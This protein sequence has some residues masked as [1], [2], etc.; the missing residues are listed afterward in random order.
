MERRKRRI[1]LTKPHGTHALE[2]H[3]SNVDSH[4]RSL[5]TM[6]AKAFPATYRQV[7]D[8]RLDRCHRSLMPCNVS[9]L[10]I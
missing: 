6:Y 1:P 2:T 9:N 8:F 7:P 5:F 3:S 4:H 10:R